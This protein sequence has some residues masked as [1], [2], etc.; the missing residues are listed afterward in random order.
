MKTSKPASYSGFSQFDAS[1]AI[2]NRE[3]KA[4]IL[5]NIIYAGGSV[6]ITYID[7]KGITKTYI[8]SLIRS[9][10]LLF[11]SNFIIVPIAGRQL[12]SLTNAI[13]DPFDADTIRVTLLN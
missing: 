3:F 4:I 8:V 5:N 9:G 12:L 7:T 11:L 2:P 10:A 6:N 1:A 13:D